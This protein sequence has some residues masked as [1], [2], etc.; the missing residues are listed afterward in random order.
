MALRRSGRV[1]VNRTELQWLATQRLREA[2][3]LLAARMWSGAYYLAGYAV[4]CALKACIAKLRQAEEF[5]D[6]GLADKCWTHDVERLL[7]LTG[8]KDDRDADA[9]TDPDFS[10]KWG[11]VASWTESSRYTRKSRLEAESLFKAITDKAHG[12][13]PWIK[14][15]W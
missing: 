13:F 8:F 4:E 5:P 3:A 9:A 2:K 11:T 6:K 7:F 14:S 1:A 12:V 10:R 15:R